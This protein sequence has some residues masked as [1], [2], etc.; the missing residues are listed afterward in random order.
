[1][2]DFENQKVTIHISYPDG[3]TL[4]AIEDSLHI[5]NEVFSSFYERE[6]ISLSEADEASA[7]PQISLSTNL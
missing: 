6:R 7:F 4:V 1:M 3:M 2:K 5:L